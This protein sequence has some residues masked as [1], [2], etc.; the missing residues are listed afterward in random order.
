MMNGIMEKHRDIRKCRRGTKTHS[1][2]SEAVFW[3]KWY[4]K[5]CLKEQ[6][7]Q[8]KEK[9]LPRQRYHRY[10]GP[11]VREEMLQLED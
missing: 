4:Q 5:Q 6:L 3:N 11:E 2:G 10:K 1:T 8:K 9:D 7:G